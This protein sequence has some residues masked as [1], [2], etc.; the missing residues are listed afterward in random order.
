[1]RLDSAP[2]VQRFPA[3]GKCLTTRVNTLNIFGFY[4][5]AR[6]TTNRSRRFQGRSLIGERPVY[7]ITA[8]QVRDALQRVESQ[9]CRLETARRMREAVGAVFR[10]AV[11][12]GGAE[13][14]P[15]FPIGGPLAA[16]KV[17]HRAAVLEPRRSARCYTQ[18][19]VSMVS[20]RHEPVCN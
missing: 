6:G 1:M 16:P 2:G 5:S 3:R 20:R 17:V 14:D 7:A 15:T 4:T 13:N 9:G 8:P 11:A 10:F 19:T 12:T 18:S